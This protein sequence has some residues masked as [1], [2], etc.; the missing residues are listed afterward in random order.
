[1]RPLLIILLACAATET[2][3]RELREGD[4][5]ADLLKSVRAADTTPPVIGKPVARPPA[6]P[7]AAAGR[8]ELRAGAP[9]DVQPA[10]GPVSLVIEPSGEAALAV[11]HEERATTVF[12][13]DMPALDAKARAND[14]HNSL[15]VTVNRFGELT[16]LIKTTGSPYQPWQTWLKNLKED[17]RTR[18][19]VI[20]GGTLPEKKATGAC[21]RFYDQAGS[22]FARLFVRPMHFDSDEPKPV[23]KSVC[24]EVLGS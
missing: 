23:F 9:V 17:A 21:V 10:G 16:G 1:M 24:G 14:E 5:A 19:V 2:S 3:A 4:S 15:Y 6:E 20:S 18:K 7:A 8:V 12:G 22:E 13:P 11:I